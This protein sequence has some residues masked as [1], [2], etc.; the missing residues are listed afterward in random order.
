MLKNTANIAR[1]MTSKKNAYRNPTA[2]NSD[3]VMRKCIL[4]KRKVMIPLNNI[5]SEPMINR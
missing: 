4:G 3:I 5:T 2:P 1:S